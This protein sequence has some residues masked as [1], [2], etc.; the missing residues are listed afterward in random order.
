MG[1]TAA[2][3]P[4]AYATHRAREQ[5]ERA[6]VSRLFRTIIFPLLIDSVCIPP[7]V[8][9]VAVGAVITV[10]AGSVGVLLLNLDA[11]RREKNVS[12]G[13]YIMYG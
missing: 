3:A 8:R 7:R 4:A 2:G 5:R 6:R 1:P 9:F 11:L 13:R 12:L 10:E